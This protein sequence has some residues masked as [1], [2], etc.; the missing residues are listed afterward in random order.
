MRS[1]PFRENWLSF[2]SI[3]ISLQYDGTCPEGSPRLR[4]AEPVRPVWVSPNSGNRTEGRWH[5]PLKMPAFGSRFSLRWGFSRTCAWFPS[6]S[7]VRRA[8]TIPVAHRATAPRHDRT[9]PLVRDDGRC[10]PPVRQRPVPPGPSAVRRCSGNGGEVGAPDPVPLQQAIGRKKRGAILQSGSLWRGGG[11]NSHL[12][13]EPI[14]GRRERGCSPRKPLPN[15]ALRPARMG[16]DTASRADR[17][18][19][20]APPSVQDAGDPPS[21]R[22]RLT[23]RLFRV[24]GRAG[25]FSC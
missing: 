12:P 2:G 23:G 13:G 3:K 9:R 24:R 1:R 10:R 19:I 5:T 22:G 11:C 16:G 8:Q 14:P 25:R 15:D 4:W 20:F 17:P 7:R 21:E 18:E 6:L